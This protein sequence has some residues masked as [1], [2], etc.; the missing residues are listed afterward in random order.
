MKR[1]FFHLLII[2]GL[3]LL[4]PFQPMILGQTGHYGTW[5]ADER[6]I[7]RVIERAVGSLDYTRARNREELER[8]LGEI[9]T[10]PAL[11]TVVEEVWSQWHTDNVNPASIVRWTEFQV[12]KDRACVR[13]DLYFRDWADNAELHGEGC[14]DLVRTGF[15]WRI[16]GFVYDWGY[17]SARE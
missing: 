14:W 5:A 12:E 16:A 8:L 13:A 10:S 4:I 9:Y 6:E 1:Y 7:E 2:L 15:G 11:E 3:G 17:H